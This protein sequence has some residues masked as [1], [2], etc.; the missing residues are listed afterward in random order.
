MIT[1]M[2]WCRNRVKFVCRRFNNTRKW[3]TMKRTPRTHTH[4]TK[5]IHILFLF[6][7]SRQPL[8]TNHLHP[9]LLSQPRSKASMIFVVVS[10]CCLI[11][12]YGTYYRL[13]LSFLRTWTR[14]N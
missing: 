11:H 6:N 13:Q 7:N 3:L 9:V 1:R 4:S 10:D 14:I 12:V 2:P 8:V 5:P